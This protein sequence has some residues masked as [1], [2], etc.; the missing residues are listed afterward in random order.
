MTFYVSVF[1]IKATSTIV[2]LYSHWRSAAFTGNIAWLGISLYGS[3]SASAI[4]FEG[5]DSPPDMSIA[6][7]EKE[8]Y[9]QEVKHAPFWVG[10]SAS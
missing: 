4:L 1:E 10:G 3:K 6:K 8:Y 2:P 5:F 7:G 9:L